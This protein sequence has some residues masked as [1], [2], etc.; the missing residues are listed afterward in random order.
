M[1]LDFA[2]G[3]PSVYLSSSGGEGWGEEAVGIWSTRPEGFWSGLEFF[4]ALE[5]GI[6]DFSGAWDLELPLVWVHGG[7]I[8]FVTSR[9]DQLEPSY[10]GCYSVSLVL[11]S[12]CFI[13]NLHLFR[14]IPIAHAQ[15]R[16]KSL[17]K[18]KS[19]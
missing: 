4:W 7:S 14:H 8:L 19:H 2:R 17:M 18:F 5:L 10:V 9:H 12:G 3:L 11:I 13:P 15:K 6:W 16:A 1:N